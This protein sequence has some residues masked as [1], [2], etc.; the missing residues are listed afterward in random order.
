MRNYHCEDYFL[1]LQNEIYD[2]S[3]HWDIF[4]KKWKVGGKSTVTLGI[5]LSWRN[6]TNTKGVGSEPKTECSF[7]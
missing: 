7:F 1:D 6:A 5:A 4:F 3:F 2:V